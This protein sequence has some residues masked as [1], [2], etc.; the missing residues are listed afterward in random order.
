MSI[1]IKCDQCGYT[2]MRDYVMYSNTG[3]SE[4]HR[5]FRQIFAEEGYIKHVCHVCDEQKSQDFLEKMKNELKTRVGE[6]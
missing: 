6:I 5:Q 2:Q 3:I 4:F 1:L